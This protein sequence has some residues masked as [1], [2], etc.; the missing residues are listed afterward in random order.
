M[1]VKIDLRP[2]KQAKPK[3]S[4]AG[5]SKYA[6]ILLLLAFVLVSGLTIL[7]GALKSH[8]MK[9]EIRQTEIAL[10]RLS[11]QDAKL[12]GELKRLKQ[13]EKIYTDALDLLQDELP[14]VEFLSL[15]EQ[16]L[17]VGVWLDSISI[18]KGSVGLTGNAYGENDV[19]LFARGLLD[20]DLVKSVSFPDTRRGKDKDGMPVVD[21]GF[22][23]QINDM[24]HLSSKVSG[25]DGK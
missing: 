19:V 24:A 8:Y 13:Q 15:L 6:A 21:F 18:Q 17:P 1:N 3:V 9:A 7:Y 14:T 5:F 20:S 12:S 2:D 25:G 16:N 22:T 10:S 4:V 23:C 11:I